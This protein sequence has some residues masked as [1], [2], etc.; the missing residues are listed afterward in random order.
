MKVYISGGCKNGKSSYAEKLTQKMQ[1]ADAPLYYLA[2]MIPKDKEDEA[3]IARHQKDR[4]GCGFETIEVG[5]DIV[6]AVKECNKHGTFLL[7]SVTA[8]LANEMFKQNNGDIH[9]YSIN[10]HAHIKITADLTELLIK[11]DNIVII[12][13]FI[14]SDAFHY[15]DLTEAYRR[16]LAHIDIQIA[17]LCDM[18]IELSFGNIIT[19]K[20]T[21]IMH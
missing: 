5:R 4:E 3:R 16:S 14:Y 6:A 18:V 17:R 9:E 12:S 11:L 2:T 10:S 21:E 13:D 1:K 19:H 15:D 7:D 20:G 8:L